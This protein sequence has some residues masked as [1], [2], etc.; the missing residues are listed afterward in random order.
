MTRILLVKLSSMGDLI[1]LLPALSDA[2]AARPELRFDWVADAAFAEIP[3]WHP[4]VD[5]VIVSAHRRWRRNPGEFLRRGARAWLGE[6]RARR[7]DLV[8]DAQGAW[9]SALV[10][11]LARGP[12]AGLDRRSIR[13]PGAHWLYRYRHPVPRRQLAIERWR[14]LL[15]AAIGYPR[16]AGAPDFGLAGRTWP[17]PPVKA[18]APVLTFIANATWPTKHWPA[19]H[20]RELIA[21]AGE[22]GYRVV[23]PWGCEPERRRAKDLA[24]GREHVLVPPRMSLAEVAGVLCSSAA[25][26]SVD[27][28]LAHLAAALGRPTLTLY[29]PTDPRLIAATGPGADPLQAAGRPCVPCGRRRCHTPDYRGPEARCLHELTPALAWARLLRVLSASRT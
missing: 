22:A 20:W 18:E 8:I 2:A 15:A 24:A 21:R 25:V 29:G 16:P 19:G 9:K 26:L 1:Q 14:A 23:L 3:R 7:Y 12:G 27:T 28:G 4:A 13:E 6:L 5:R 11:A 10:T 17:A